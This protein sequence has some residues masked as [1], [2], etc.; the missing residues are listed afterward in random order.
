MANWRMK[1]VEE[2]EGGTLAH[3]RGSHPKAPSNRPALPDL[4]VGEVYNTNLAKDG[5]TLSDS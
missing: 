5:L 1:L 3:G 2:K 4:S